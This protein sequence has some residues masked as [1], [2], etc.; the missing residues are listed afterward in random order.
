MIQKPL[1]IQND[2]LQAKQKEN[3]QM[4]VMCHI[5]LHYTSIYEYKNYYFI[6]LLLYNTFH[7]II[8]E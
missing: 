4:L 6:S 7:C 3:S 8:I 2:E 5:Y 1:K